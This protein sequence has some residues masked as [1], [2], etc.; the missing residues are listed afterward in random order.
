MGAEVYVCGWRYL[1]TVRDASTGALHSSCVILQGNLDLG[2]MIDPRRATAR[3]RSVSLN[4]ARDGEGNGRFRS[5]SQ[6]W[7]RLVVAIVCH[8]SHRGSKESE[9]SSCN[10]SR[11]S[12]YKS[13]SSWLVTLP[14]DKCHNSPAHLSLGPPPLDFGRSHNFPAGPLPSVQRKERKGGAPR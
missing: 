11:Y 13:A 12:D 6:D 3:D 1:R 4:V 9:I 7:I 5:G 10:Y 14:C 8:S 2:L